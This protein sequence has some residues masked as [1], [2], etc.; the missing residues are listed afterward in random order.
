MFMRI[1]V[2]QASSQVAKN[3]LIYSAVKKYAA[4]AEVINFGCFGNEEQKYSYIEISILIGILLSC[5]AV[6]LVVTGC[7]S[8]QGMM[9]AC[10]NMPGVLCGYIPTPVDAYLFA[11]INDGNAV[12]LPLG[13]EYTWAG[14]ENLDKT[15]ARLF[16]EPFGQGYPKS[17]AERKL[18]D[19]RLLKNIRNSSQVK[20]T[21]LL[22]T[23]EKP[24]L[25]KVLSKKDVVEYV[26]E[27]GR[28]EELSLL[29]KSIK[30]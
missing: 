5:K 27:N 11:Q 10:N 25:D 9:L 7:S 8:G 30:G 2:I 26:L 4:D 23:L 21:E 16:S 6:D 15:I 14:E 22:K 28:D 1:A 12:S 29:I 20:M 18:A 13:E 17:E 3:E 24:L 19:T